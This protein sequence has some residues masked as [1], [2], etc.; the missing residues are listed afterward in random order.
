MF[1]SCS[2]DTCS[3]EAEDEAGEDMMGEREREREREGDGRA[4]TKMNYTHVTHYLFLTF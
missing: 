4:I 3:H 2:D 1:D